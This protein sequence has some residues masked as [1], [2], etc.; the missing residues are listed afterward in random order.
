MREDWLFV[1]PAVLLVYL[2]Q[3]YLWG[4]MP[5]YKNEDTDIGGKY[6][7]ENI[8]KSMYFILSLLVLNIV[9]LFVEIIPVADGRN[10]IYLK[11]LGYFMMLMA[12]L[13]SYLSL[14]SLKNNW[15]GILVYRIKK[16]Q[17]L[18]MDGIYSWI[19][20]PMYLAIL[21]EVVGYQLITNSWLWLPLLIL[22]VV[23]INK[24]ID[25]EDELLEE[26]YK[27]IFMEY[28]NRVKRLVPRLY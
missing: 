25:K 7:K 21:I 20:H 6:T 28:K 10:I 13:I 27:D 9:Q 4:S 11:I 2:Q 23:L 19:R 5:R 1:I 16:G 3:K 17:E 12:C 22:L 14:K 24:H 15:S 18:I 8:L 26:K